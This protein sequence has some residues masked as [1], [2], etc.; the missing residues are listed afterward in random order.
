EPLD[1]AVGLDLAPLHPANRL[2]QRPDQLLVRRPP[3]PP[4]VPFPPEGGL[5]V[6]ENSQEI[7][8]IIPIRTGPPFASEEFRHTPLDSIG[9]S[10]ITV[11]VDRPLIIDDLELTFRAAI[12][13]TDLAFASEE[14]VHPLHLHVRRG[15]LGPGRRRTIPPPPTSGA[16][17]H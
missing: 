5:L 13:G 6:E 7:I 15:L 2:R 4:A 9:Y 1:A 14:H 11:A 10:G 8:P 3:S 16:S 12:D 17:A